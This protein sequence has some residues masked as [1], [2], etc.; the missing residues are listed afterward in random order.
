MNEGARLIENIR[1]SIIGD[2]VVMDGPFGPRRVTYADY[3]ASGRSLQFIEE[4]VLRDTGK[5]LVDYQAE[6]A[7]CIMIDH[8]HDRSFESVVVHCRR[9][10]QKLPLCRLAK[11]PVEWVIGE[12]RGSQK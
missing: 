5:R 8:K 7:V 2:D 6:G 4:F 3:T 12:R 1:N 9:G 11:I 10:Y